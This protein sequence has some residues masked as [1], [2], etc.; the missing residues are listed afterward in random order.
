MYKKSKVEAVGGYGDYRK[1]QDTDL[2]IKMLASG[3]KA[4]NCP[5]Y[6]VNFR[7]EK[8]T[9]QKRK[10]WINTKILIDLRWRAFRSGFNSLGDFLIVF[11]AQMTIYL[12]PTSVQRFIYRKILR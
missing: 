9:Y 3:C 7:F 12:I 8:S 10:S 5:E 2:W 11:F 1:N 4:Q 6:L